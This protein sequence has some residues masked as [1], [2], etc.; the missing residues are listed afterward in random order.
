MRDVL[1]DVANAI[2][3][4]LLLTSRVQ[5]SDEDTRAIIA[6]VERA[7]KALKRLQPKDR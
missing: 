7:A 3:S 2:Q 4:A 6:S 1:A 5:H